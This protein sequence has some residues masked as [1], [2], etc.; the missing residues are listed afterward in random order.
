MIDREREDRAV[1]LMA[2]L[3]IAS[4][5][6]VVGIL[7]AAALL[8]IWIV[9]TLAGMDYYATPAIFG[10]ALAAVIVLGASVWY[11]RAARAFRRLYDRD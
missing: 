8:L 5:V 4:G 2:Q 10:A 11:S 6:G 3:E 9:L 7:V 1:D